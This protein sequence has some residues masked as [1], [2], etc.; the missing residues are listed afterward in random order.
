MTRSI[1]PSF[2]LLIIL[3]SCTVQQ[4]PPAPAPVPQPEA[5]DPVTQLLDQ[6][7]N[8]LEQDRLTTPADNNAYELYRRAL[9][10]SPGNTRALTGISNI[11]EQYLSWAIGNTQRGNHAR[12]R[13][14]AGKAQDIDPGHP[15]I[16]AVFR[17]INEREDAVTRTFR[18]DPRDV[19][20][21][22]VA[23]ALFEKMV[24]NLKQDSFVTIY[25]RNDAEGRWLYQ[26]LNNR[27]SFRVQASFEQNGI[28]MVRISD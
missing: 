14:Y 20:R 7:D 4:Q 1:A 27:V 2:V 26:Q 8:A 16:E 3:A 13:H 24:S 10:L 23:P 28:P 21:R 5:P 18:L 6:A 9:E 17:M 11:V 19:R 22:S 15:S 12:A 25:A